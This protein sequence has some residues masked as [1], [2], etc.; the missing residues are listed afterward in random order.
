ME[1][2]RRG[3]SEFD[4]MTVGIWLCA[5]GRITGKRNKEYP[6]QKKPF[7]STGNTGII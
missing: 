3:S 4:R 1:I 5:E 7:I 2:S 6:V